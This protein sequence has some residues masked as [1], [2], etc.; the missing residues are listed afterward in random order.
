MTDTV[1]KKKR[2]PRGE[3][4]KLP[5]RTHKFKNSAPEGMLTEQD[6]TYLVSRLNGKGPKESVREAGYSAEGHELKK[7]KKVDKKLSNPNSALNKAFDE[8]GISADVL[9]DYAIELLRAETVI[10][11]KD[12]SGADYLRKIVDNRTR[13]NALE[14][15][16]KLRNMM[17]TNKD[18]G[19]GNTNITFEQT[20]IMAADMMKDPQAMKQLMDRAKVITA[21]YTE[22]KEGV[23]E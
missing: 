11:M 9:A 13:L 17:P 6:A 23:E 2:K 7:A 19:S 16:I 10:K 20:V 3:T 22:V 14:L 8:K 18:T 15:V 21:E 1:E 12:E 5:S 4:Q